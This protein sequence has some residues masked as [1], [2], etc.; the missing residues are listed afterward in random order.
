MVHGRGRKSS[1][2]ANQPLSIHRPELIGN[3]LAVLAVE[4]ARHA[5]WVPMRGR[6]H[7]RDHDCPQMG[8]QVVRGNDHT[9]SRLL[10]LGSSRG[11]EINEKHFTSSRKLRH[12]QR[13][14]SS[15]NC[16]RVSGS[17]SLPPPA[18]ASARAA[19]AQPARALLVA[20][21]TTVLPRTSS[22][23]SSVRPAC[24]MMAFGIRTPRELPMRTSCAFI[25]D[26]FVLT[27]SPSQASGQAVGRGLPVASTTAGGGS[28]AGTR[29][30]RPG[31][32][33]SG[34]SCC[35]RTRRCRS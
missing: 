24:S 35:W 15:S 4:A 16:V 17:I 18:A 23:T 19:S 22:S 29:G 13:H 31:C 27:R 5:E 34:S 20:A 25:C 26:H 21:I 7:G 30:P 14:S 8:V 11:V 3:H 33:G 9:G 12:Y 32:P 10:D 1:K 6:G 2:V 28:R